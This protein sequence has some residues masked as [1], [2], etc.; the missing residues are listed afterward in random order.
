MLTGYELHKDPIMS[1][2]LYTMQLSQT[3]AMKKRARISLDDSSVLIG[4][5]DD[6]GLLGPNEVFVQIRKEKHTA[7]INA[8]RKNGK[9]Q[10]KNFAWWEDLI[11]DEDI[12]QCE[13]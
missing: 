10:M 8:N 12:N 6:T 7:K 3:L 4:V 13:E 5:V 9:H 11:E 1:S 2:I